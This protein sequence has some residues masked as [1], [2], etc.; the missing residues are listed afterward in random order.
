MYRKIWGSGFKVQGLE[1]KEGVLGTWGNCG[2]G[3]V[4]R[5]LFLDPEVYGGLQRC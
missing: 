3:F 1:S 2:I 5:E 4:F